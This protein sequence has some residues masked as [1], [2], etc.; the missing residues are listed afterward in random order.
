MS[1]QH[2]LVLYVGNASHAANLQKAAPQNWSIFVADEVMDALAQ[3]LL[4]MPDLVLIDSRHKSLSDAVLMH[5]ESV[6]AEPVLILGAVD[7]APDLLA[8][9]I[10]V[11]STANDTLDTAARLLEM[12][13]ARQS[14][15][16]LK[17]AC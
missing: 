6:Q 14:A 3:Y 9:M 10:P 2:P 13:A 5:L 15:H 17:T 7:S 11:E 8:E 1:Q 12:R 16:Y 4:Y